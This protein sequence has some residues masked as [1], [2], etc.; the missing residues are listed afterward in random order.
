[1]FLNLSIKHRKNIQIFPLYN[2]KDI[3]IYFRVT[4]LQSQFKSPLIQFWQVKSAIVHSHTRVA[5]SF[6]R[7]AGA[8]QFYFRYS[9]DDLCFTFKECTMNFCIQIFVTSLF[10]YLFM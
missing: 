8:A 1:M 10:E 5:R 4:Y 3:S 7:V 9:R 6:P 2:N